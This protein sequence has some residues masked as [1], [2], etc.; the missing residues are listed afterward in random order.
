MTSIFGAGLYYSLI[1]KRSRLG[2]NRGTVADPN[3]AVGGDTVVSDALYLE[4]P[5][6]IGPPLADRVR[7]DEY[8]GNQPRRILDLGA[9]PLQPFNITFARDSED[10]NAIADGST[11]NTTHQEGVKHGGQNILADVL[12]DLWALFI[13]G[14]TE[15]DEDNGTEETVY[16]G[17]W[18]PA[19][20][21]AMV[22]Q[23]MAQVA[24]STQNPNN[25]IYQ[26]SPGRM[27]K[28]PTGE[29]FDSLDVGYSTA[30]RHR[31][32]MSDDKLFQCV[33][34]LFDGTD[35]TFQLNWLPKYA[36]VAVGD[37]NLFTLDGVPT[38]LTSVNI[39]T[40]LVTCTAPPAANKI[41][42]FFCP[43]TGEL[44]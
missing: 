29:T 3:A 20:T 12:N 11:T 35:A 38:A 31:I 28:L 40:G 13:T 23:A 32:V 24:S 18:F 8:S 22:P 19:L 39:S 4:H 26:A 27:G 6:E 21:L 33:S 14:G 42:E 43:I 1:G 25:I 34:V 36:D 7:V 41:G 30:V 5:V 9:G 2:Y 17:W 15:V 10:L 16:V 37:R 44:A